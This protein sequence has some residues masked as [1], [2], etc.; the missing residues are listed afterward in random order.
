[1]IQIGKNTFINPQQIIQIIWK[2]IYYEISMQNGEK[3]YV[4]P[5]NSYIQ[6]VYKLLGGA[7]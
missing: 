4:R 6:N 3:Y 7:R 1:M 5:K 2:G